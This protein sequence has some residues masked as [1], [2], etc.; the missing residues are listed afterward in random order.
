ME[1][2]MFYLMI[3]VFLSTSWI[4]VN[5]GSGFIELEICE[6]KIIDG[7]WSLIV[8]GNQTWRH[9]IDLQ[10]NQIGRVQL[11]ESRPQYSFVYNR[12]EPK[13]CDGIRVW[14]DIDTLWGQYLGGSEIKLAQWHWFITMSQFSWKL[15]GKNCWLLYFLNYALEVASAGKQ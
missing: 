1:N 4:F 7:W 10:V 13:Q 15:W 2:Q 8:E 6:M 9:V 5:H 11:N 14:M 12:S 3:L